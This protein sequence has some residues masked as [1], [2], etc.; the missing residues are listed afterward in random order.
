MSIIDM[1]KE[2]FNEKM[3]DGQ[4]PVLVEFWAPWCVYCRRIA[5]V[6]PGLAKQYEETVQIGK[7]NI[8][9]E[10]EIAQKENIEVIPT[11]ILYKGGK[12]VASVVAPDSKAK[13]EE[14]INAN[15]DK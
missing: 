3:N 2:I 14:F 10:Q 9:E 4:R 8:D 5:P 12:A 1:N 13:L 15:L 6:L 11:F 7:V